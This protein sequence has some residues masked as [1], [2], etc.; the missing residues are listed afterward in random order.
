MGKHN[1]R[2]TENVLTAFQKDRA[3]VLASAGSFL[4]QPELKTILKSY[5]AEKEAAFEKA[6]TVVSLFKEKGL[7]R[8][9]IFRKLG[10]VANEDSLSDA[11]ASLLNPMDSHGLGLQPLRH[12]LAYL[13]EEWKG[14][15]HSTR[16]E[17]IQKMLERNEQFVSAHREKSEE[18]T[19]PDITIIG[20]DFAIFIENK[21]RGGKE[22]DHW[23]GERQT[24]RQGRALE[25]LADRLG[26][27]EFNTLGIFLSPEGTG[28]HNR[29][30][31]PLQVGELVK[32]LRQSVKL[33]AKGMGYNS[34]NSFLD[35]YSFE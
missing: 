29:D 16:I 26:I 8:Y 31:V 35:F 17:N 19:R 9:N 3:L 1:I 22:T 20:A 4:Q 33:D 27:P 13:Q 32:V 34:I 23:T 25:K 21:I 15:C 7:N 11:I 14:T 24:V 5:R 28:A 10:F 30:F 12:L 18:F 2:S 6:D